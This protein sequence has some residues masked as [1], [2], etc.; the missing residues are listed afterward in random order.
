MRKI[1]LLLTAF[2]VA[3]GMVACGK[4]EQAESEQNS[5]TPEAT[6]AALLDAVKEGDQTKVNQYVSQYDSMY[7]EDSETDI[8]QVKVMFENVTYH[9]QS[10]DVIDTEGTAVVTV[11]VTNIDMNIVMQEY[12]KKAL[13]ASENSTDMTEEEA[14]T[15]LK[16][17]IAENKENTI[18][19]TVDLEV[20]RAEDGE[21]KVKTTD[22]LNTILMGGLSE[23]TFQ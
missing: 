16:D 19:K 20:K 3:L 5:S 7:S 11:D 18:T 2:V 13:E 8:T 14:M 4:S 10:V 12:M 9:I 15:L 22:E 6:V 1:L 17:S 21:W 23:E